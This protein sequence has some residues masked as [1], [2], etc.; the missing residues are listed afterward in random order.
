[1]KRR[2]F[3]RHLA[4]LGAMSLAEF[5]PW[6]GISAFA[7][8]LDDFVRG[9]AIK[10]HPLR[11]VSKHVWMIF[12]PDGFPTPENQGMM[13]NISFVDTPKGIVVIDS[14]ASVQ[15]GEMAIRQL[16]K[17]LKKPVVAIVNTHYHGD[18][19]LGNDAFATA[20]L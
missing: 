11:Q 12:S 5:A 17:T 20:S 9:P 10:D 7:R 3:L 18:H 8:E 13:C 14:G 6:H 1:M 4:T 19:W 15:I 2:Y 16:N